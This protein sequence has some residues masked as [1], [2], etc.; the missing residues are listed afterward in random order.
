MVI[1]MIVF[2]FKRKK[3]DRWVIIHCHVW[4]PKSNR[5][6]FKWICLCRMFRRLLNQVVWNPN[7]LTALYNP[8]QVRHSAYLSFVFWNLSNDDGKRKA[9]WIWDEFSRFLDV[10]RISNILRLGVHANIC[11]AILDQQPVGLRENQHGS[12]SSQKCKRCPGSQSSAKKNFRSWSSGGRYPGGGSK[13]AKTWEEMGFQ[14]QF[15]GLSCEFF[16]LTYI[17]REIKSRSVTSQSYSNFLVGVRG[18]KNGDQIGH[19]VPQIP[20]PCS[21]PLVY[22]LDGL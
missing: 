16:D 9:T 1:S 6:C 21:Q 7:S 11:W 5:I 19:R 18:P 15:Q 4:L 20:R 2:N 17:T 3:P 14:W 13:I 12:I 22:P 10:L 8:L